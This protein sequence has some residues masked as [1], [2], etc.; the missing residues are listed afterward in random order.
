MVAARLSW[1]LDKNNLII[2]NQSGF[3]KNKSCLD[4]AIRLF[5]D[6]QSSLNSGNST[7]AIFLDFKKAFDLIWIDGLLIKLLKFNINGNMAR[8]I[9]KI[10]TNRSAHVKINNS[11]S[12]PFSSSN[13]TPRG[14]V[15]SPIL[16]KIFIND[17]P[18]LLNFSS[19]SLFTD[20]SSIWR[21]GRCPLS[22]GSELQL[23]LNIISSWCNE[24]GYI[25]NP[26]SY[27]LTLYQ[28]ISY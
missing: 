7:I 14:C 1:Y 20:D 2:P 23:N 27:S 4:N 3:C 5:S 15:I 6:A 11:Y 19:S 24:C 12:E 16:F 18:K 22:I 25:I 9:K 26:D 8:F 17:F 21:S 13:G 10:L 28:Q